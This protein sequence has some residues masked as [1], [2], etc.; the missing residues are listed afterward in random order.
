MRFNNHEVAD[1]CAAG[2]KSAAELG[3][4]FPKSRFIWF[5]HEREIKTA[6]EVGFVCTPANSLFLVASRL[7]RWREDTDDFV[8]RK[9]N[10]LKFSVNDAHWDHASLFSSN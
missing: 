9:L 1:I 10:L 3:D 4:Y 2:V 8:A 6:K 5:G 7:P